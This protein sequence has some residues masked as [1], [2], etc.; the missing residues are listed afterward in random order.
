[1]R[2]SPTENHGSRGEHFEYGNQL[3]SLKGDGLFSIS[4]CLLYDTSGIHVQILDD[5][6][7][8]NYKKFRDEE[9]QKMQ[10]ELEKMQQTMQLQKNGL[11]MPWD[12]AQ[13][14]GNHPPPSIH[15]EIPAPCS[16]CAFGSLSAW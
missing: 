16:A 12:G 3:S 2:E 14:K 7:W 9:H 10:A 8:E 11:P 13:V 6:F 4:L 1:M 15:R 5:I